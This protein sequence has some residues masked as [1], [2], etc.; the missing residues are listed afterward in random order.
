MI[1]IDQFKQ[2]EIRIGEIKSAEKVE[3]ADKLLRLTVDFGPLA[4]VNVPGVIPTVATSAPVPEAEIAPTASADTQTAEPVV[5][6]EIRQI[7]SGIALYFPDPAVLVGVKCAFATNLEPRV[8][9]GLESNGMILAAGGNG[10]PFTLLRA[11]ADVAPG[12]FIK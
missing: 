2:V 4:A 6:R 1:T 12:S 11:A 5:T 3:K 10:E 9:R 7:V 8:I